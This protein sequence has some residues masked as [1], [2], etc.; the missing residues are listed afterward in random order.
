MS[1]ALAEDRAMVPARV[2]PPARSLRFHRFLRAFAD[3]PIQ[4]WPAA[5]YHEPIHRSRILGRETTFVMAPDL[6]RRVLVEEADAFEKGAVSRRALRPVLGDAILT[7]D[8]ARW[9]WQRRAAAPI[10]RA[11]RILN[12]VPAMRDAAERTRTRWLAAP[13]CAEIDV[14]R[15]MMR[16]TFDV[17]LA[18]MLPGH[19]GIDPAPIEQAITDYIESTGWVVALGML[20]A[21]HWLPYPGCLK[22]RRARDTL[23]Q[24]VASL[25]AE[26]RRRQKGND[27]MSLLMGATDPETLRAMDD[28]DVRD[29]LL[30]FIT[31]GHETTAC[32]LTWTF[33]LLSLYPEVEQRIVDEVEAVTGGSIL[34]ADHVDRL[35][36][37]KRVVLEAMRLYPPAP[38]VVRVASR[39]VRLGATSIP[40][41]GMLWI[42]IYAVHRH[43]A[44]WD[45]PDRFDP[46][47]FR[48]EAVAA[49]DRYAYL[50]FGA[51]PRICIG[52]SFAQTEA[53]VILSTLLKSVRLRAR[54][55]HVP[56]PRMRVTL[57]PATGMPM[58][59]LRRT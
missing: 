57:R 50:P 3:N 31:A 35:E 56:R 18:T 52:M 10:L 44:L 5:I 14:A 54:D 39:D 43:H 26:A 22:A 36:Y 24:F 33:Y 38:L 58:R 21:P 49:R 2:I 59:V 13:A 6:I 9:R 29:N 55:G 47:R 7:A 15:E 32:A 11:D 4:T 46:E 1:I 27:L 12:F 53:C 17:I 40:R 51:G 16:T 37:T 42:P 45:E 8:G 28:G 41:G 20:R 34:Q 23:K 30:T 19:E 25:I 48:P